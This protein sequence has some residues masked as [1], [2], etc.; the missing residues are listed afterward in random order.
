MFAE[1]REYDEDMSEVPG[2]GADFFGRIPL[3]REFARLLSTGGGPVNWELARQVAVATAS[4]ADTLGMTPQLP[5]P[6]AAPAAAP[7]ASAR[8]R[9]ASTSSGRSARRES[10]PRNT[11]ARCAPVAT[12]STP[13]ISEVELVQLDSSSPAA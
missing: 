3:F 7:E 5:S 10:A 13:T 12:A 4:G 9:K 8:R 6:A 11:A 2:E 1:P